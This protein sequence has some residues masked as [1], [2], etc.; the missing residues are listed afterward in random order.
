MEI[1]EINIDGEVYVSM[2]TDYHGIVNTTILESNLYGKTQFLRKEFFHHFTE[3][4]PKP[5]TREE[6]EKILIQHKDT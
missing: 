6:M 2:D 5:V 1:L 4:G 3:D